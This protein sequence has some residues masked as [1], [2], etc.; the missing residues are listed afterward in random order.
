MQHTMRWFG[1]NDPVS[2]SDIKQAGCE[3]VVSALHHLPTGEVWSTDEINKRKALIENAGLTWTVVESLPVHEEIKK[4]SGDYLKYITHYQ[5]SMRNLASCGL[6]VITYNF[7]PVLDWLRTDVAYMLPDGSKALYFER[8][9]FIAF[10]LYLLKRPGAENDY[11]AE[12]IRIARERFDGMTEGERKKL[13]ANAMLGL[14]G[15]DDAFTP[16]QVLAELKT[17]DGIN[18][19]A[20]QQHLFYFLQQVVPVAEECGLQLAIHPDDPPFAVLGLPRVVCTEQDA[21]D[22]LNAVPSPA[23]GL[24]F[25][26]GSFGSRADNDLVKMVKRFGEHIHFLHLR[27]TKRDAAGNFYEADHLAGDADMYS[28][29]K[30]VVSVMRTR[31]ISIPMRPD[32]GH[33]MLDDLHKKTYPGYSAI[34]RLKGLA[35]LRGLEYAISRNSRE[36]AG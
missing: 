20:L 29:V 32:H 22:L 19:A 17:F 34:G 21:A 33:Q 10:D 24:C 13:F 14:P 30:E 7:M 25:C 5:Q 3:G 4:Q 18:K 35:E 9:A 27:N 12:E 28:I 23:N 31:N 16:E 2:L 36:G 1:P 8:A 6:K 11:T 26:T 15:T